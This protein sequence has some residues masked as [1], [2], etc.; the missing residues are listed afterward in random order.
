[1]QV[2]ESLLFGRSASAELL[3]LE[4]GSKPLPMVPNTNMQREMDELRNEVQ[5][6]QG[7]LHAERTRHAEA[8]HEAAASL[9]SLQDEIVR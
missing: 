5:I 6:L 8:A 9:H 1:M 4:T 7:E 3:E 2:D